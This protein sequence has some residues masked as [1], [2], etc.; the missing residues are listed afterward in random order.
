MNYKTSAKPREHVDGIP[1]FCSYDE[2]VQIGQVNP[3][4]K[5]PNTHPDSQVKLLADIIRANGWRNNITVSRRSGMVV[6][7]HGR[8]LAA[9]LLGLTAVPVEYQEYASEGEELADLA[10]DNRLS[11]LSV[12]DSDALGNLLDLVQ[13]DVPLE[14]AGYSASVT[15]ALEPP[16]PAMAEPLAGGISATDMA[17]AQAA[18]DSAAS[19]FGEDSDEYRAFVDKFV[20]KRTT[21]DCFTP[22]AVFAAIRDWVCREYGVDPANIV[23]PFYPGG[24]YQNFNYAVDSVVVDNPPF[25]ILSE[26]ID[27]YAAQKIR[28][29]LF[30]QSRTAIGLLRKR[31]EACVIFFDGGITYQNGATILT[32]L[33]TNLDSSSIVKSAPELCRQVRGAVRTERA[34]VV[35]QLP[36]YVYPEHVLNFSVA[37]TLARSGIDFRV[38]RGG[39]VFIGGLDAQRESGKTIFGGGLLLS[40]RVAAEKAAAEKFELSDREWAIVRSLGLNG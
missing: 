12:L 2:L 1:I 5:N 30:C 15:P 24:D 35:K 6:R 14:L 26:I 8:L 3:N 20:P 9:Q 23:R 29:C 7:G 22:P 4:P 13:E 18:L 32:A 11:E 17:S 21:D 38:P 39:G 37:E 33:V 36:K 16:A 27:F 19:A 31:D 28:Y 25:S 40:E 34:N 10:A